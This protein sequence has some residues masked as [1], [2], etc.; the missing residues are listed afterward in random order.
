MPSLPTDPQQFINSTCQC[1]PDTGSFLSD[2]ADWANVFIALMAFGFSIYTFREQRRKDRE[3]E[4][5]QREKDR[6]AK[7]EAERLQSVNI[8]LQWY[9]DAVIEPNLPKIRRFFEE[10]YAL[11]G[12]IKTPDLSEDLKI[13]IIDSIKI[14]TKNLK[15]SYLDSLLPISQIHYEKSRNLLD[16]L[17]TIL[18]K[19]IDN[20]ELKLSNLKVYEKEI[21]K[22]I[23]ET[24]MK[25]FDL[26]YGYRGE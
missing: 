19:A 1:P 18:I 12:Q 9:K 22:P 8:R 5:A 3:N 16:S 21:N 15:K 10:L 23:N 4:A 24:Y 20:D 25:L 26:I 14:S 7:L 11:Q 2:L 13:S 17:E 6:E